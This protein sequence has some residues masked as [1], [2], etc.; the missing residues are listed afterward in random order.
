MSD[1][2]ASSLRQSFLAQ[3]TVSEGAPCQV[4]PQRLLKPGRTCRRPEAPQY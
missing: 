3:L 4:M 2:A 1:M